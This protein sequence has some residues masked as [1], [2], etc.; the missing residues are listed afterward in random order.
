MHRSSP[1]VKCPLPSRRTLSRAFKQSQRTGA[2]TS[3]AHQPRDPQLVGRSTVAEA[4]RTVACFGD[5][6]GNDGGAAR[7]GLPGGGAPSRAAAEQSRGSLRKE[8]DLAR[9]TEAGPAISSSALSSLASRAS[10]V[11]GLRASAEYRLQGRCTHPSSCGVAQAL[12][13]VEPRAAVGLPRSRATRRRTPSSKRS[14]RAPDCRSPSKVCCSS[15]T[16]CAPR[17]LQVAPRE[18]R[19]AASAGRRDE[20]DSTKALRPHRRRRSCRR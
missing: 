11:G 3:S 10:R 7:V 20:H 6:R 19:D 5:D 15:A 4:S 2:L 12:R 16:C 1:P 14:T 17:S 9:A 18:H 8:F 13:S